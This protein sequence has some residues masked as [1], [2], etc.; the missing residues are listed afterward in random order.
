MHPGSLFQ[1]SPQKLDI[2]PIPNSRPILVN[3]IGQIVPLK[4]FGIVRALVIYPAT[5]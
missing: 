5:Y 3:V 1:V 4:R 2:V